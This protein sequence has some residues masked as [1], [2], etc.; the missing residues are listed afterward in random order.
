M[1]AFVSV[2]ANMAFCTCSSVQLDGPTLDSVRPCAPAWPIWDS[3]WLPRCSPCQGQH[4]GS[5][6][7][8]KLSRFAPSKSRCSHCYITAHSGSLSTRR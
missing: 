3:W 8:I 5:Q 1:H 7:D 6:L 2:A 4:R